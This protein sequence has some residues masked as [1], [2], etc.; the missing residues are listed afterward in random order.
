MH[1]ST[2]NLAAQKRRI[3]IYCLS[4]MNSQQALLFSESSWCIPK[5]VQLWWSGKRRR[6]CMGRDEMWWDAMHLQ[7]HEMHFARPPITL[8][9]DQESDQQSTSPIYWTNKNFV[10]QRMPGSAWR[11]NFSTWKLAGSQI[12]PDSAWVCAHVFVIVCVS[13]GG[14]AVRGQY[15]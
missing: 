14:V 7:R 1:H 12:K 9:R 5:W 15:C 10:G 4:V 8:R 6:R 3:W 13:Q 11:V 2:T